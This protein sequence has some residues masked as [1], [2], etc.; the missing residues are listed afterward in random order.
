MPTLTKYRL[1]V[2]LSPLIKLLEQYVKRKLAN[3]CLNNINP[4]QT[5]FVRGFNTSF[6]L[7]RLASNC[8]RNWKRRR[9][10]K[11]KYFLFIDFSSAFDSVKRTILYRILKDQQV[12]TD[13]EIDLLK[14]IHRN[15]EISLH[16]RTCTTTRGVPK[17]PPHLPFSST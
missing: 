13:K 11:T 5:G 6:N 12:L 4:E 16:D 10:A 9:G 3:F 7:F 17:D 14:F 8:Y 1:I 2:V 15:I